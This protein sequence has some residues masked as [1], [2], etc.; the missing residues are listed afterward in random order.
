MGKYGHRLTPRQRVAI[1]HAC[2]KGR[3]SEHP[4]YH[5]VNGYWQSILT[6][7]L[8]PPAN[9]EEDWRAVWHARVTKFPATVI[10]AWGKA[11]LREARKTMTRLLK[12]VGMDEPSVKRG[13]G[14]P[15][16]A[17]HMYK[18]ATISEVAQAQ[19]AT[20]GRKK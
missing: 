16:I 11:D 12:N 20:E 5:R 19:R 18:G 15:I 2:D 17:I 8:F 14:E 7:D 13:T 4:R 10:A 6:F 9:G 3:D 1:C